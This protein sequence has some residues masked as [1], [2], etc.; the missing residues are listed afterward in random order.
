MSGGACTHDSI[1]IDIHSTMSGGG[2]HAMENGL[3]SPKH[4]V[5]LGLLM[6]SYVHRD[7]INKLNG[8]R[9]VSHKAKRHMHIEIV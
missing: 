7:N 2:C 6:N 9:S 4:R 8:T 3:E 5:S 1:T